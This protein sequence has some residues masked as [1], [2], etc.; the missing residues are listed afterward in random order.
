MRAR[1]TNQ[2]RDE[3]QRDTGSNQRER[4]QQTDGT[5]NFNCDTM[6]PFICR[7]DKQSAESWTLD[8]LLFATSGQNSKIDEEKPKC[9]TLSVDFMK[10]TELKVHLTVSADVMKNVSKIR[11]TKKCLCLSPLTAS[12]SVFA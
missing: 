10:L 8:L 11:S 7:L 2:E 6:S 9:F 12:L 3:T 4:K 5:C 1:R